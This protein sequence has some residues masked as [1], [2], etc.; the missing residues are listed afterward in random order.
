[1]TRKTGVTKDTTRRIVM[2][3]GV[4]VLN[5]ND[6]LRRKKLGATRGGSVFTVE[7]EYRDMP[8]DG[9]SGIVEGSR[10]VISTNCS[11][12]VNLV[13]INKDVI[14]LAVPGADYDNGTPAEDEN[15]TVITGENHFEVT[16]KLEET[17]PDIELNEI[18]IFAEYG[19]HKAPVIC[20]IKNAMANSNLE[21][22]F[23]DA[24]EAVISITF[25]GMFD[26]E[27]LATEPWYIIFP[28]KTNP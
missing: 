4:V 15:G 19:H 18:A 11:L 1:M 17:I 21:I 26:V 22:N 14:K 7:T 3:S 12:T 24:D 8:F 6:P 5:P 28:E 16:R 27:D 25:T 2:D 20:G 13:E 9:V 23:N 10:R